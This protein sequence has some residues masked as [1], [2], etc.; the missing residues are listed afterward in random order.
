MKRLNEE[1]LAARCVMMEPYVSRLLRQT[2]RYTTQGPADVVETSFFSEA[3]HGPGGRSRQSTC[4]DLE[5]GLSQPSASVGTKAVL[6]ATIR[7][8]GTAVWQ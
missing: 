8:R 3:Q 4:R 1:K 2:V 5:L 6:L 7:L